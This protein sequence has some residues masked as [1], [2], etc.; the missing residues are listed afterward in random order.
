MGIV[1]VFDAESDLS[2]ARCGGGTRA[3]QMRRMQATVLCALVF[4][5]ALCRHA[6][7]A[8]RALASA[9]A[10]HWWRDDP[11]YGKNPFAPL[12]ALF[13]QAELIVAYNGLGFDF[14]LLRKHYG[15]G[16]AAEE[17]YASHRFK[18]H[19]PMVRLLHV[20]DV[21][22]KLDALLIANGL[23]TKTAD[24][25]EAIRMWEEGE[26]DAL[27]DYCAEDVRLLALFALRDSI[28]VPGLGQLSGAVTSIGAAL[29]ARAALPSRL[30]Q[31]ERVASAALAVKS[32]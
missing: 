14:P 16:N 32:G 21:Q 15:D 31:V 18:C 3:E 11:S 10:L 17:R 6:E 13:D 22:P 25:L 24:G 1:V 12:L 5:A 7:D 30:L 27:R 26:R 29:A 19:D 2:F 28:R 9:T 23:P 4:D 20:V 8:E